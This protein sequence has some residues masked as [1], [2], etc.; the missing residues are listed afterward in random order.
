[1][2]RLGLV[3]SLLATA[4]PAQEIDPDPY[5]ALWSDCAASGAEACTGQAAAACTEAETAM[6]GGSW[7]EVACLGLETDLW[8]DRIAADSR[9]LA[10]RALAEDQSRAALDGPAVTG[11]AASFATAQALWQMHR[12][13]DCVLTGVRSGSGMAATVAQARCTLAE[14]AA[15]ARWLRAWLNEGP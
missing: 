11:I 3:L 12:D 5:R 13:A 8:L 6:G 9:A 1:M 4:S 15:R 2:I 14:T 7:A 10:L